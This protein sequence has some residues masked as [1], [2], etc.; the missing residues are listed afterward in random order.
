LGINNSI[1]TIADP[2][3]GRIFYLD[4]AT[5]AQIWREQYVPIFHPAEILLTN[6]QAIDY[7]SKLGYKSGILQT[8]IERFQTDKKIAS[9][10]G[11]R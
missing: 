1:A 7:L 3:R 9:Q 8:D 11:V 4:R 10:R 5:F 6:K 2:A